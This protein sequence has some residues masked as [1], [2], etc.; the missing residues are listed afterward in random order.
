MN[1]VFQIK[2]S[3]CRHASFCSVNQTNTPTGIGLRDGRRLA[4]NQQQ[5]CADDVPVSPIREV[6]GGGDCYHRDT[7]DTGLLRTTFTVY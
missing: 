1:K 3:V 2:M 5:S 7:G 4:A 6:E